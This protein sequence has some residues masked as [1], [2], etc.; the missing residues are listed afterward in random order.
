MVEA[1]SLVTN[2]PH[3]KEVE[4]NKPR[5]VIPLLVII[6]H[7]VGD[8]IRIQILDSRTSSVLKTWRWVDSLSKVL[9]KEKYLQVPAFF[10]ANRYFL[11]SE[12]VDMEFKW[13][14]EITQLLMF[15][16][17]NPAIYLLEYYSIYWSLW[18][19][20]VSRSNKICN[21]G[22]YRSCQPM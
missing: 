22:R 11:K 15:N 17:I 9:K 18:R 7:E 5:V 12:A 3:G 8:R 14:M 6:K 2:A 20:S 19:G 10:Q 16:L 1:R 4:G 13:Q 21:E